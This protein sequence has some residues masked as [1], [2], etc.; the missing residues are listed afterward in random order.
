MN[1]KESDILKLMKNLELTREEAIQTLKDDEDEIET[2]EMKEMAKN[3]KKVNKGMAKSV[4]AYGKTR[5]RKKKIDCDKQYLLKK[6]TDQFPNA[7]F[8]LKVVNDEREFTFEYHNTTY[9][10]IMSVPRPPKKK[11]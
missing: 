11:A 4:D 2:P 9:K 7:T 3:A 10:V 1:Y 6:M 5:L 8:N